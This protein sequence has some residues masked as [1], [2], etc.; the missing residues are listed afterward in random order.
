[1]WKPFIIFVVC[2]VTVCCVWGLND[3]LHY[4]GF[5][6]SVEHIQGSVDV[7]VDDMNAFSLFAF[8]VENFNPNGTR[9][10]S[11]SGRDVTINFDGQVTVYSFSSAREAAKCANTLKPLSL[12][13]TTD[14]EVG[15]IQDVVA[16][17]NAILFWVGVLVS[18]V[19]F[20]V[21]ILLDFVGVAWGIVESVLYLLGIGG[22]L[23]TSV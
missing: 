14:S 5:K 1:M 4:E 15:L 18:V 12:S 7:V 3:R 8:A 2:L 6:A 16:G 17:L 20:L 11:V 10:I 23:R 9:N 22:E 19:M 13:I 21:V